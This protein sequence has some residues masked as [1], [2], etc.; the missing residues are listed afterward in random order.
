MK[1][2]KEETISVNNGK[3]TFSLGLSW[4][5]KTC[6]QRALERV[7]KP[8]G[9]RSPTGPKVT[10]MDGLELIP[11]WRLQVQLVSKLLVVWGVSTTEWQHKNLGQKMFLGTAQ[12]QASVLQVTALRKEPG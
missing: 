8:R 9:K 2:N 3:I 1:R 5:S 10:R 4:N 6:K 12:F 11:G 7:S